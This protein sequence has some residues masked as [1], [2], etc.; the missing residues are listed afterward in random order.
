[1][2][3]ITRRAVIGSVVLAGAAASAGSVQA[4]P[5]AVE[6]SDIKK[7]ADTA[8]IYHAD[9][10]DPARFNL[11]LSNISNHYSAVG[12]NPLDLQLL[13]VAVADGV[14][15]FLAD[16]KETPWEK[17]SPYDAVFERVKSFA[18]NGLIV[19]LCATTLR[20][21]KIPYSK[22]RD[23]NFLLLVPSGVATIA[24]LQGKGFGYIKV[25]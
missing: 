23:A 25:G 16:L 20:L 7:E 12:A 14:K 3:G 8:C 6:P 4:G 5:K 1:M 15:F 24:A 9:F 2:T 17:E 21:L 11:M 19:Y 18:A 22:V 10:G 13:I